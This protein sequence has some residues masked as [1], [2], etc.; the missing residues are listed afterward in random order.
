MSYLQFPENFLWG[1]ATASYQVE[2][3][4]HED[5]RGES[6]WDT[7][8]RIPGKVYAGNNGDVAVDQYHRYAEDVEL[9]RRMSAGAYRFSIAWPRIF[10]EGTGPQNP[11]GFDYY[12]R[13]ID[14]LLEAGI[15]PAAT[16]Y[17]W[18]L[19]QK[20]QDKGGWPERDTAKA[21]ADYAQVC[22][23]ELGDKV[24]FWITLNEP[25]VSSV[26]GYLQGWHAPGIC[27]GKLFSRAVHHLNLGHG[28]AV[29][30]YRATGQ[31]GQI[32]ATLDM[33]HCRP[34][35][36]RPEDIEAADA[37]FDR[38][39]R[40]HGGPIMGKGYPQRY[41]DK[42]PDQ[43]FPIENGDMETIASRTDFL[44]LNYYFQQA[45]EHN[46]DT[47]DGYRLAGNYEPTTHMG[48]PIVPRGL[49]EQ[50]RWIDTEYDH[51]TIYIT[52]NGCACPDEPNA[53]GDRVHDPRRVEYLRD[54]FRAACDA[55]AAGVDLRGYFV[56]SFIDNFE[57]AWGYSRRFGIVYCDYMT[58][59]RIPKDS[60]YF[61]RDVFS[62]TI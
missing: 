32:G 55:I 8:C 29:Q 45:F 10:P 58:L 36:D 53:A 25:K 2:G 22:F 47:I 54:H 51:P 13:L 1:V 57:W 48:W 56:W 34:A 59:K 15:K 27:D 6:I 4:T 35:T 31:R 40:V 21:F 16:L 14:A 33:Q 28:L 62:G 37:A 24:D 61:C 17:H 3:A 12:H 43:P 38:S 11:K 42:W 7:F 26:G 60:Y 46:P 52:E 5:G 39:V 18:D 20:L 41:L 9:M 19:P 30:A 49:F 44:G 50:L 23:D